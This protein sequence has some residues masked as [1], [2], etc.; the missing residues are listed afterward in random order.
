M[1]F[2]RFEPWVLL[3]FKNRKLCWPSRWRRTLFKEGLNPPRT[4]TSDVDQGARQTRHS[5]SYHTHILYLL[6]ARSHVLAYPS[7]Y[8]L[9]QHCKDNL[10]DLQRR[11]QDNRQRLHSM[12][13]WRNGLSKTEETR[14]IECEYHNLNYILTIEFSILWYLPAVKARRVYTSSGDRD[15]TN[16]L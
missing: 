6:F 4:R 12:L 16:M 1:K 10:Y 9:A 8:T 13:T 5:H 15:K 14:F 11:T 2:F 3:P 7:P